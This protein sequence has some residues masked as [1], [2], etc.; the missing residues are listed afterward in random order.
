M[1]DVDERID[2]I[3]L[4][5][6]LIQSIF[7]TV[8]RRTLNSY[9]LKVLKTTIQH[10][11]DQHPFMGMIMIQD[12]LYSEG[13]LN[14]HINPEFNSIK[15]EEISNAIDTLIRV[16]HLHLL[17]TADEDIGLFFITELK[18]QLSESIINELRNCNVNLEQIQIEQHLLHQRR[19]RRLLK[20]TEQVEEKKEETE[21]VSYTWND[22]SSWK[23]DNNVCMLY[24]SHGRLLDTLQLDL[25]IEDYVHRVVESK[26]VTPDKTHLTFM[27]TEKEEEFL[28]RL[29]ERDMDIELAVEILH[30]SKQ[31]LQLMIQKLLQME[32][33]QYISSNEVKITDKG[34]QY[35]TEKNQ[36]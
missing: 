9:A 35:I 19:D 28:Q 15:R 4:V 10:L 20:I 3:T 17:D 13:G 30:V 25:L 2:N 11:Q 32:M 12:T 18:D 31:R 1:D 5:N 27:I 29:L 33:L 36:T 26:S 34:I 8:A 24:D 16:I 21:M 7:K 14:I 6:N 23:Y 22:V